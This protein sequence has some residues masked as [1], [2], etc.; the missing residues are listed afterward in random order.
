MA[1]S[2]EIQSTYDA[3]GTDFYRLWLD[4]RMTYS[5]AVWAPGD[6][7]ES[8]QERKFDSLYELGHV[9]PGDHVL[10]IGCGWGSQLEYGARERGIR[11]LHG[12]TM[13]PSQRDELMRRDVPGVTVDVVDYREYEPEERFDRVISI[14]MLEH[15]ATP[16]QA[17]RGELVEVFRD[18][19]R[20]AHEWTR[21]GAWFSLHT[22]LLGRIPRNRR[23]IVDMA[24]ATRDVLPG[25]KCGRMEDVI[26]AAG[27]HWEVMRVITRREDYVLTAQAW[28]DRLN[29]HEERIRDE[30]G[31][32]QFREYQHFLVSTVHAF[33]ES[34]AYS[35]Q[36]ALRRIDDQSQHRRRS[37]DVG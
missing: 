1:T 20:R 37:A 5:C 14:E 34:Y 33:R 18:Y 12:I 21:P 11:R 26:R 6:T 31:D 7:L 3:P 16:E 10:D 25:S 22:T 29:A 27:S 19:F 24:V 15:I 28:A 8:A 30:F 13:S 9:E 35:A 4:R 2:Q 32:E 23:D 36:F 17:R